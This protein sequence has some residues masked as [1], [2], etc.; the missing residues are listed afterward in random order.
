MKAIGVKHNKRQYEEMG[1]HNRPDSL[2]PPADEDQTCHR[3]ETWTFLCCSVCQLKTTL[4]QVREQGFTVP[5]SE[6]YEF[7]NRLERCR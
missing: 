6:M 3:Q 5:S 2:A 4:A 1:L 7:V